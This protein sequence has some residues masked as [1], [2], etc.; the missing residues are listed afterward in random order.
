MLHEPSP[1]SFILSANQRGRPST[2][3]PSSCCLDLHSPT[4]PP[5]QIR[6]PYRPATALRAASARI[7][8][9]PPH[10]ELPSPALC[11]CADGSCD[12]Q[13][14]KAMFSNHPLKSSEATPLPQKTCRAVAIGSRRATTRG[15]VAEGERGRRKCSGGWNGWGKQGEAA[16]KLAV[17][18]GRTRLAV[19][20][21]L[22]VRGARSY[23]IC[24]P[25]PRA[26]M[27]ARAAMAAGRAVA[28]PK[29]L[30]ARTR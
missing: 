10:R 19:S 1:P 17:E 8:I 20:V 29:Q 6:A 12:E 15:D 18:R 27:T 5:L 23:L 22:C 25:P 13:R 21:Q 16:G 28:R 14:G 3:I 7:S 26:S 9:S 11:S 2:W 4:P 30:S 24:G